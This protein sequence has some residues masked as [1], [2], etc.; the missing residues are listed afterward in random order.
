[1]A[2]EIPTLMRTDLLTTARW[3]LMSARSLPWSSEVT[4]ELMLLLGETLGFA[5]PGAP[6]TPIAPLPSTGATPMIA[7]CLGHARATDEGNVG[8]GGVSEEDFNLP[9]VHLLQNALLKRG[10]LASVITHYQGNGYTEAMTWLAHRL[11]RDGATGAVELHFNAANGR[12]S[13]HELLHWELSTRGI[14]LAAAI[15]KE[16]TA[17]F[18]NHPNRGLKPKSHRDRGALFLSLTHC[19]AVIVEPFF[20]DNP[21]EWEFFSRE[22]QIETYVE[23]L[24]NGIE[25]WVRTMEVAS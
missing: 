6:A 1:M 16:L 3:H 22:E 14:Q 2:A 25:R 10:I 17:A 8:A 13:G 15:D 11:E 19:P 7:I 18:P 23:A 21:R 9:I 12:A 24:A 20:G 4:D 5:A